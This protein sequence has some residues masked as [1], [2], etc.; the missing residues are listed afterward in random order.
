MINIQL[1]ANYVSFLGAYIKLRDKSW[2][3][4][5]EACL[6]TKLDNFICSNDED[7]KTLGRLLDDMVPRGKKMPNI[8]TTAMNGQV[9]I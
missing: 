2:A 3:A 8:I 1:I 6:L 7:A 9:L 5:V 4:V